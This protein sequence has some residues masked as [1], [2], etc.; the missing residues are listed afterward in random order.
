MIGLATIPSETRT[1][2]VIT[3]HNNLDYLVTTAA[4]SG[5]VII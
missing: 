4:L 2:N 3:T 1:I 5:L